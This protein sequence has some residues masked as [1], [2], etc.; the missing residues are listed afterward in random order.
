[1]YP[2]EDHGFVEETSWADEYQRILRLFEQNLKNG[3]AR[4]TATYN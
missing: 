1:M 2:V 3:A 4:A